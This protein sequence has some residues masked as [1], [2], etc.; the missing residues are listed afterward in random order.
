MVDLFALKS[1]LS[2]D[3]R[4]NLH[5]IEL[6]NVSSQNSVHMSCHLLIYV[7]LIPKCVKVTDKLRTV[8]VS[9]FQHRR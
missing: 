3:Q 4:P 2:V 7:Y 1:T 6:S 5:K 9:L 8:S